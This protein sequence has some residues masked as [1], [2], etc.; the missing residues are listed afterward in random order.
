MRRRLEKIS[1]TR[2]VI[3][4]GHG[5]QLYKVIKEGYGRP[6]LQLPQRVMVPKELLGKRVSIIMEVEE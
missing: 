5:H 6:T 4:L 1:D 2:Y 3:K